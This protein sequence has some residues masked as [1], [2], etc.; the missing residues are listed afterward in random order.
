MKDTLSKPVHESYRRHRRQLTSQILLPIVLTAILFVALV[1][2][3]NIS[4]FRASGDVARWAAISTMWIA[5]P[6][7][8]AGFIFLALLAGLIYLLARL[9]GIAPIYTNLAQNFVH[10]LAIRIRLAADASVKPVI[11]LDGIG[12]SIKTF[13]GRK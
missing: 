13:F 5:V 4:T 8:I 12:A 1:V 3:I 7:F 2:L 10:K 11:F 9:L 6:V